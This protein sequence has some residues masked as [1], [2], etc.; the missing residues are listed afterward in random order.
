MAGH[1]EKVQWKVRPAS[2]IA[3][4]PFGDVLPVSTSEI[5][6]VEV[7]VVVQSLRR[8]RA[9]GPDEI[10]AEYLQALVDDGRGLRWLTDLCNRC[11]KQQEVPQQWSETYV[12]AIYKKC[13]SDSCDNYRPISLLCV[14]YKVFTAILL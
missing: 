2:L 6:E 7:E 9:A 1:L 12:K 5:S 8:N 10:P 4:P 11:W 13:N 14:A 3:E